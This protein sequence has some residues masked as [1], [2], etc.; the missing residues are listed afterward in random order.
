MTF[1]NVYQDEQL[2]A[3]YSRLEL[4]GTYY[5][6]Y[7]DLP[8]IISERV[9]GGR[10]L[11]FGCGTGR[12]TRFLRKLGFDVVGADISPEM[13]QLARAIDPAG[14][15]R[16][17]NDADIGEN[18]FD[19]ILSA[20]T[21]DNVPTMQRKVELFRSLAGLLAP[22]GRIISLGSS[23]EIY[24]HQWTSFSTA[25]FPEN[26]NAR[27][28][29]VVRIINH[30]ID[31]RR[32]CEDILWTDQA[33]REVFARAGLEIV[34]MHEPLGRQDEPYGWVNETRIAPWVIYV[35][36]RRPASTP[37]DNFYP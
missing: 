6:A 7:R 23:P 12:S 35:L 31:D 13:L 4:S 34:R 33:W 10:A 36:K 9:T 5:L 24:L 3:A 11:D 28:G 19:L 8:Q 20:F 25:E 18:N 30:A 21:F 2:A 26:R 37:E 27:N 22:A 32:P 14:D 15:Y 16:L 17:I 1:R 29:D